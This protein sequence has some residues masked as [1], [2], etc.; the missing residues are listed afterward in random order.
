MNDDLQD[1][2]NDERLSRIVTASL[3]V[4]AEFSFED[5]TTGEIARRAR[6]S[7]RDI[8]VYFPNKHAL[9]I[10]TMNEVLHTENAKIIQTIE[11][12][13]GLPSLHHRLVAIGLR[14]IDE[15]LSIAMSVMTRLA[16][17][18]SIRQ[19]LIGTVFFENGISRRS[20]LVSEVLST[21]IATPDTMA[22]VTFQAA[23]HFIALVTHRPRLT[24]LVGMREIWDTGAIQAHAEAAVD[25]FLRAHPI[26]ASKVNQAQGVLARQGRE[27]ES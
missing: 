24:A 2:S 4:F 10:G 15:V 6:V 11:R 12:T 9:L 14:L 23:E 26:F 21:Y 16:A 8:Y 20:K 25:C 3:E 1:N 17:S 5:A 7:K 27:I 18:E 22:V 13:S 19:P